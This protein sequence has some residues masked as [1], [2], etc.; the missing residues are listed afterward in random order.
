MKDKQRL[1]I[2]DSSGKRNDIIAD[3]NWNKS[4]KG[5]YIRFILGKKKSIIKKDHLLSI[6]FMLGDEK[7]QDKILA[8]FMKQ[9]NITKFTK[10]IGI[11]TTR[12]VRKGEMINVLLDFSFNPE[13]KKIIIGKGS[14]SGLMS[15]KG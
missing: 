11:T 10:M 3:I 13:T 6:L 2:P 12:D 15:R 5:K 7:E 9:T 4:S 1:V 14:K 8:P